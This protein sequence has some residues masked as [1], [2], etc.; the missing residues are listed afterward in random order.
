MF[1]QKWM[2]FRV[3]LARW[4]YTPPAPRNH[5]PDSYTEIEVPYR[6]VESIRTL[7]LLAHDAELVVYS[8]SKEDRHLAAARA[9]FTIPP[10]KLREITLR[11]GSK[12]LDYSM[13][14]GAD[15]DETWPPEGEDPLKGWAEDPKTGLN[16]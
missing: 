7:C 14:A 15:N 8:S 9:G 13:S 1:K 4:I 11:S 2:Q 5:V 10:P 16:R 12:M 6:V 3:R